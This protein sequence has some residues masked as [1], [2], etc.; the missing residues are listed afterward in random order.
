MAPD[1]SRAGELGAAAADVELDRLKGFVNLLHNVALTG[2]TRQPITD[3]VDLG[4]DG[5]HLGPL[6]W[7][8]LGINGQRTFY[9]CLHR[10]RRWFRLW[11]RSRFTRVIGQ[12]TGFL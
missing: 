10:A 11:R 3:V 9:Q 1:V 8:Q 6:I 4:V 12:A 2:C 7:G 5:P